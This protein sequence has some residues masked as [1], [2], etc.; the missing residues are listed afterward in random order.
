MSG[1]GQDRESRAAD[2][3]GDTMN[4]EF[5]NEHLPC[6]DGTNVWGVISSD[7]AATVGT[8]RYGYAYDGIGNRIQASANAVTNSYAANGLNQYASILRA[9]ARDRP[10]VRR[11]RKPYAR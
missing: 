10:P 3:G 11:G 1:T 5:P 4:G 9:S 6:D 7:V 2:Q 8:N